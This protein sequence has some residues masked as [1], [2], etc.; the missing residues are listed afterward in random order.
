MA[1]GDVAHNPETGEAWILAGDSW[2]PLAPDEIEPALKAARLGKGGAFL[3]GIARGMGAGFFE[4]APELFGAQE[5]QFPVTT[6]I[7]SV[8]PTLA[9]PGIGFGG[10]LAAGA[11][12][13]AQAVG[14][15]GTTARVLGRAGKARR[16]LTL[17]QRAGGE[18]TA[19]GRNL[20][21]AR[22]LAEGTPGLG[23]GLQR[24]SAAR[25]RQSGQRLVR[26]VSG[27]DEAAVA[28]AGKPR[29]LRPELLKS[30]QVLKKEFDRL[31]DTVQQAFKRGPLADEAEVLNQSLVADSPQFLTK[32][33]RDLIA[34]SDDHGKNLTFLRK[35]FNKQLGKARSNEEAVELANRIDAIDDLIE[36]SLTGEVRDAYRVARTKWRVQEAALRGKA[37]R[38]DNTVNVETLADNLERSFGADFKLGDRIFDDA[39]DFGRITNEF[40]ADALADAELAA[41]QKPPF[42]PGLATAIA[43]G[44][45]AGAGLG[46]LFGGR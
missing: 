22:Q 25:L 37:V 36:R 33:T 20:A 31:D 17:T 21:R 13:T 14:R 29:G 3:T 39:D 28:R 38:R 16:G 40:L 9:L 45:F 11:V 43:L 24:A 42:Q 2:R 4:D 7:G 12:K 34:K 32:K 30:R 1:Q 27:G 6:A 46:G 23:L 15:L 41:T 19:L 26:F 10:Q 44:G 18:T 8:A 35:E 5:Q